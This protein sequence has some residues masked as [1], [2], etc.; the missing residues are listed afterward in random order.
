MNAARPKILCLTSHNLDAPDYG[1]VIRA[2]NIFNALAQIGDVRMVLAGAYET[3][4]TDGCSSLGGFELLNVMPFQPAKNFSPAELL[5]YEFGPRF[6]NT[7]RLKVARPDRERMQRLVAGHDL[8]WIHGLRIANSFGFFRWP[9]SVLDV[10]DLPGDFHRTEMA[11]ANGFG[12]KFRHFR[13]AARW[14]RREKTLPE[15]FDAICVCSEPDRRRLGGSNKIFVVPNG[16]TATENP[17]R[18]N[19]SMP[20]RIGFIGNLQ[21]PPNR[22]GVLWFLESVWP[23]ILRRIPDVR[24]R[25]AG[26][27][28]EREIW[29]PFQN[30]DR[31]GWLADVENEMAAWSL[32]IVPLFVGGGTRIKIAEAFSRKC[33]VVS[34]RLGAYGYEVSDGRELL[35]A[36]VPDEFAENC[37][38]LLTQPDTGR[39]MAENARQKFLANWTWGIA[40]GR[41]AE[42]AESVLQ[43]GRANSSRSPAP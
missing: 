40:A 15:R 36:D 26:A 16:F 39:A 41:V 14:W 31:L 12:E 34:T 43:K 11:Q 7:H 37:V 5:R 29:Q 9:H 23:R 28:S 10:D 3:N 35:L 25:L 30:V 27:G 32:A 18:R 1:A 13:R 33:P 21:Y 22:D 19:P 2:R 6:L 24:L 4:A 8:V 42:V 20:P 38:R 17:P